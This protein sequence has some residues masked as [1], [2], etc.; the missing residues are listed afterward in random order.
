M[1]D[2]GLWVARLGLGGNVRRLMYQSLIWL[3]VAGDDPRR[4]RAPLDSEDC[5][6]LADALI[7]GV[8]RD[9]ELPGDFLGR[10]M[11]VDEQ[12]AIELSGRQPRDTLS[13][14]IVCRGAVRG[15]TQSGK[16]IRLWQGNP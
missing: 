9:V 2:R 7:D 16:V 15:P 11:L 10:Q 12:Q 14:V 1:T 6:R 4:L 3:L 5:E 8:R 13:Q